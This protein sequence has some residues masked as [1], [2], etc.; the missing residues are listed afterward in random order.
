MN[1]DEKNS[2]AK[3]LKPDKG[4]KY[5]NLLFNYEEC[6]SKDLYEECFLSK[7]ISLRLSGCTKRTVVF[8]QVNL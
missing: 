4:K 5:F 1:F 2:C 7:E 8:K 3:L 6:L